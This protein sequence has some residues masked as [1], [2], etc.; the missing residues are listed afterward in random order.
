MAPL[1]TRQNHALIPSPPSPALGPPIPPADVSARIDPT[2]F[3]EL[4][5]GTVGIF[6]LAVVVWKSGR[7]IRS[8]NRHRVLRAG[9]CPTTRYAKTWYGWVKLETHERNKQF[10]RNIWTFI[11]KWTKWKT[12][13]ADYQWVWWDP[14]QEALQARIQDRRPLRWLPKYLRSYDYQTADQIWNPKSLVECHGA[15]ISESISNT[16]ASKR[17]LPTETAT[18]SRDYTGNPLSPRCLNRLVTA[19]DEVIE[20][21]TKNYICDLSR[22]SCATSEDNLG[23]SIWA[24]ARMA[25]C[26]PTIS[27]ED[28]AHP[29]SK[30]AFNASREE[31]HCSL[32]NIGG[33]ILHQI[34]SFDGSGSVR[35][36]KHR[37]SFPAI[38]V[39]HGSAD[40][41]PRVP[42]FRN[43]RARKYRA[44][45]AQMQV[46]A[47]ESIMR[48]QRDSS[49]PP[50]TPITDIMASLISEQGDSGLA[51]WHPND[52]F[53]THRATSFDE[54]S[55]DHQNKISKSQPN[56]IEPKS[57]G[58]GRSRP[59]AASLPIWRYAQEAKRTKHPWGSVRDTRP[60]LPRNSSEICS[61]RE[62]IPTESHSIS[63][64][65]RTSQGNTSKPLPELSDWE[66]RLMDRLDRKL[67]WMFHETTPGQK[68]YHFALLANHWLNRETWLVYDPVSRTPSDARRRNGDPRYN[69]PY[70]MP[71]LSPRPKY[72]VPVRRKAHLPK[73]DSWRAAVNR[74]RRASG[75]QDIT[76][77]VDIYEESAE[78]PPDG[79][80]DPACWILP[81][82][83]QGFEVSS[84]QKDAWYEGGAGWHEKLEDWQ[85]VRRGYRL[86]KHIHEGRAHRNRIKEIATNVNGY[87][88]RVSANLTRKEVEEILRSRQS[89]S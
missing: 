21:S 62:D 60:S 79:H 61:L 80:I 34:Q 75:I 69:K 88:R 47:T 6:I 72:P 50:G 45:A 63:L 23:S 7:C 54:N 16:P 83:P 4:F 36:A 12:T 22:I 86:H 18:Q 59:D 74:H 41:G 46:K 31:F 73:I 77:R 24:D 85:N 71:D 13:R 25:M 48:N 38:T 81:K 52:T 10:F 39:T 1:I 49:G 9:K 56:T 57:S 8:F 20:Q 33:G 43:R 66:I 89:V 17:S 78:E 44:W 37:P 3:A 15:L 51:R 65:K 87:C 64:P 28:Q 14:N 27:R 70:Q 76:N 2:V 32:T 42:T 5:A 29:A 11:N 55:L 68:P 35:V 84:K 26:S 40:R 30:I 82:P 67:G 19:N 58:R 53:Q